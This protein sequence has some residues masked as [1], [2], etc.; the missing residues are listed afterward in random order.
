MRRF[1]AALLGT[2]T[3]TTAT[4]PALAKTVS[5]AQAFDT[6]ADAF[7]DDMLKRN[8]STATYLG[9]HTYD[10]RFEDFSAKAVQDE[11]A[12]AKRFR[13]QFQA[14]NERQ[15]NPVQRADRQM[16]LAAIDGLLLT[17]ET[18]RPWQTNP[19]RYSSGLTSS[20]FNL[21]KRNFAPAET[22]LKALIA[23]EKQMPQALQEA[24]RNLVNP[25][26]VYTDVAI[27]QIDG[28]KDFFATTVT[29][30][31]AGVS[32]P[33]LKAE[34]QATN[35]AVI[36]ALDAYKTFLQK[37]LLPRSKGSF[38]LGEKTYRAKL[39]ADEMIALPLD[40][41]LAI[42]EADLRR[43]QA[44]F[45]ATAAKIDPSKPAAAVFADLAKEHPAPNQLLAVTQ[46][47]LDN[48]HRFIVD[49]KIITIPESPIAKVMETPPFLRATSSASMDTPGPFE[50]KADDAF[51]NM[52]LPDPPWSA[53]ETED[54]MQQWYT[55][56][57]SNVSVHEAY[58]GHYIQF[59]YAKNFPS[60]ARKILGAASN[61]EGWAHYCEQMMLDAGFEHDA[62]PY[63]L[64][65]LQDA[66]L[67]DVRLL[68]GIRMHTRGMTVDQAVA[69]FQKEA[70]QPLPV[71]KA[72]AKR[73]TMDPTYGYY[74]LGK[75]MILKLRDDYK[76][77]VG[78]AYSLQ[79]FHDAFVKE[80]PL[81]LPLMR[82]AML[83]KTGVPL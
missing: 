81:P 12:A 50:P 53:T 4:V 61:A 25:P 37:D 48:I 13:A 55:A 2:I 32:D 33:A 82:Q 34:F 46:G 70:Y 6:L 76:A 29:E 11:I 27:S 15:L 51:Y 38:A 67:R 80:G 69:T 58:P 42:G 83:G 19:D 45:K 21:I 35:T 26:Q 18:I 39:A 79:R 60:K 74:T 24:R 30:A 47:M 40:R 17:D 23:R 65:Q 56:M 68:V 59:L 62:P 63:R 36:Q 64:A 20:A 75:L 57:L 77:K 10:D 1:T 72:E 3:L 31:F 78:K 22:R 5:P 54:F 14:V 16:I 49:Q 52:T 71:A 28:N 44:A 73:G 66:L 41:L 7:F 43:N 9:V 8:P